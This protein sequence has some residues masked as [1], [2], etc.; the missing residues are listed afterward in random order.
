[1]CNGSFEKQNKGKATNRRKN[2][3]IEFRNVSLFSQTV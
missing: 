2:V 1:M 3:I